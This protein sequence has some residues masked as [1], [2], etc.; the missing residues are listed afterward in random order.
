MSFELEQLREDLMQSLS[1][2]QG[3]D[4]VREFEPFGSLFFKKAP[5]GEPCSTFRGLSVYSNF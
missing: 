3:S 4:L 2:V 1:R 5:T